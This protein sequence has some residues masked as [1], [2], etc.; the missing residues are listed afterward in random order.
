MTAEIENAAHWVGPVDGERMTLTVDSY[1]EFQTAATQAVVE[2]AEN[3]KQITPMLRLLR[4]G[5]ATEPGFEAQLRRLTTLI[6]CVL[7][8]GIEQGGVVEA[9]RRCELLL[10][11][12]QLSA[13]ALAA[14]KKHLTNEL[15]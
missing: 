15:L 2:S 3:A 14:T 9:Q 4:G 6:A 13:R 8:D 5:C 10:A 7:H 11:E 12:I 1:H